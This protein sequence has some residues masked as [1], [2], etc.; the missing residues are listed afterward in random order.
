MK[1]CPRCGEVKPLE[2]FAKRRGHLRQSWCQTCVKLYQRGRPRVLLAKRVVREA[3]NQ[4]CADCGVQ[5][6][7][8]VMDL[9][10][11]PG[12]EKRA[13]MNVLVKRGTAREILLDE[14]AKCDVV[15]AN[16][17]RERTYRRKQN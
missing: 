13:N 12:N 1:R 8:Y 2:A 6:P 4:A 16:C 9:D 10:H 5:Y 15:C 7:H 3:K 14:I 11:L 17:H